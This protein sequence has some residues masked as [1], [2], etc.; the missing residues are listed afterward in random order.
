MRQS[1]AVPHVHHHR[2][3][4]AAGAKMFRE[5]VA[6]LGKGCGQVGVGALHKTLG[7]EGAG[8]GVGTI[9]DVPD[10]HELVL[11]LEGEYQAARAR[12]AEPAA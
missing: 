8:Q 2:H 6:G 11:R 4:H 12:L 1:E 9:D 3:H 5:V 7:A 10:T